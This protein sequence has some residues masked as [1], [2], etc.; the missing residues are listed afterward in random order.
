VPDQFFILSLVVFN[1]KHRRMHNCKPGA[2]ARIGS[3]LLLTLCLSGFGAFASGPDGS[4]RVTNGPIIYRA[5]LQY[6]TNYVPPLPYTSYKPPP[7]DLDPE[8]RRGLL[9]FML[10]GTPKVSTETNTQFDHLVPESFRNLVWTN[11]VAH[12]NG[13]N[14]VIWSPRYHPK[15]WPS[16]PPV[17]VWNTN[18]LMWGMKGVTAL[19]PCWEGE[20]AS[21]QVPITAL[22]RRHGYSRGHGMGPDGFRT[23]FAGK[24]VWFITRDNRV[25][26]VKIA[27]EVVRVVDKSQRDYSIVLFDRDLPEGI[28]TMRVTEPLPI[29]GVDSKVYPYAFG[30]P[31]P[32]FKTEQSGQVDADMPGFSV[33]TWK[34]GDSGS[35]NMLPIPGELVFVT[36]RSTSGA[37]SAMQNDMDELC[38]L[39][40]LDPRKYR[41]QWFRLPEF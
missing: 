22:T 12:T 41:L 27:R 17:A 19:S 30:G 26:E 7:L 29:F 18:G 23:L 14:P 34:G 3:C 36:G 4:F 5:L 25:I 6:I 28:D 40:G 10:Q 11:L 24:K 39:E 31:N 13:R 20:G 8:I 35:P 2:G 15:E 16:I 21:G 1:K 32:L 33:N 37:S 9:S 38:R